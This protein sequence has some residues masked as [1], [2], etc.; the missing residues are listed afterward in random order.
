MPYTLLR[1]TEGGIVACDAHVSRLRGSRPFSRLCRALAVG[2]WAVWA[3][4]QDA[5]FE[6]R[7][8]SRLSDGMPV[9][10]A[11]SPIA[12]TDGP[13]VKPAPPSPYDGVRVPGVATLLT[14]RDGAEILEACSAAVVG[15]DGDRFVHVPDDRPRVWSTAEATLRATLPFRSRPLR[16]A[17]DLPLVLVNAVRGT[18]AV[19]L[20][21]R[22]P[23]PAEARRALEDTLRLSTGWPGAAPARRGV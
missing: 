21:G 8:E 9:R 20:P 18:C 7:G 15:W 23:F 14:T 11:V 12:G 22:V 2:V 10:L 16:P 17:E 6:A 19:D 1:V 13:I 5:R 3:D 4:G